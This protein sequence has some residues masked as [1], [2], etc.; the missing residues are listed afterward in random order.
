VVTLRSREVKWTYLLS[1]DWQTAGLEV[2]DT[3]AAPAG[4]PGGTVFERGTAI[5]ADGREVTAYRSPHPLPLSERPTRRIELR[6]AAEPDVIMVRSLPSALAA[7]LALETPADPQ[8][9]VCE[10]FVPA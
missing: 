10:I 9:I 2:V 5:Q 6:V 8:S 3:T 1:P 7:N 4:A